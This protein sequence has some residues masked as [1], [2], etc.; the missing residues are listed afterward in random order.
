MAKP[1][2]RRQTKWVPLTKE[3]FRE[4]FYARYY[5]PAFDKLR[6]Q[7]EKVFEVAWDGYIVYRKSPRK[8]PAGKGYA[9]PKQA[10]PIEWIEARAAIDAAE[11][12]QK[13]AKSPTRILIVNGSTRSEHTCP[14]EISKT[15]RLAQHAQKATKWIFSISR[16][17]PTSRTRRSIRARPAFRPPNRY[18]TGH[19]PAIPT[20]RWGRSTTG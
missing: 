12:H 18:A 5:D 17:W 9:D 1:E 6:S 14:G 10:L 3:Q 2:V 16:R 8:K 15:R 7:L 13:D 11:K 20:T 19:V 4:R